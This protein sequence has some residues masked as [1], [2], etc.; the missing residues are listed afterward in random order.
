MTVRSFALPAALLLVAPL[1]AMPL[2][3]QSVEYAAGTTRYRLS[4]ST[5]GSQTSPMGSQEF[6]MQVKQQLTVNL[7]RQS[8]DT[9]VATVTLD[10]LDIQSAQ[11]KQDMSSLLG[12]RFVS[13]ISPTGKLYSSK[14]PE[15]NNPVL[16]QFTEG[17]SR[18]LPTYRKDIHAGMTWADTLN[19]KV[20][21][22]GL[23]LNRTV[24]SNYQ[25]I[26]DTNVAGEK[27]F[28]VSR[29]STVKAG[30]SGTTSGQAIAVESATTSNAVFLLSP[31][32][33]YLGGHQDDD[34]N[35]KVTILAQGAEISVKQQASSTIEALH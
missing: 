10:S 8:K 25:V 30:G 18:F 5:K 6:Q 21:Q 14:P 29:L 4:T 19:D 2:R 33:K 1:A 24:V 13:Y 31:K 9:I 15:G 26:G 12:S 28:K 23:E 17:V 7:A 27:A 3:A 34:I 35:A 20:S 22:Q 11:G 16:T 32:G